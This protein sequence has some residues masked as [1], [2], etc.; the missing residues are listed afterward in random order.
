M[1]GSDSSGKK[2]L[3]R[4]LPSSSWEVE[5]LASSHDSG[6]SSGSWTLSLPGVE[7]EPFSVTNTV[8][9]DVVSTPDLLDSL[10]LEDIE[11]RLELLKVKEGSSSSEVHLLDNLLKLLELQNQMSGEEVGGGESVE[12][13]EAEVASVPSY[14]ARARSSGIESLIEQDVTLTFPGQHLQGRA[15][16]PARGK[17]TV[18][19]G[20]D[21]GNKEVQA[22][23]RLMSGQLE[24]LVRERRGLE[25]ILADQNLLLLSSGQHGRNSSS[26]KLSKLLSEVRG[27]Q[28]R[29][30]GLVRKME[31]KVGLSRTKGLRE[32]LSRWEVITQEV[33]SL[34]RKRGPDTLAS[35]MVRMG[36]IMRRIMRRVRSL[37]WSFSL[38]ATS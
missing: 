27:E 8:S 15:P 30:L 14:P 24:A 37:L 1:T 7:E 38:I 33:W 36:R 32:S 31:L 21:S 22:S 19:R 23:V 12:P 26:V 13:P 16:A 20:Q 18:S 28:Q 6:F 3:R 5:T 34:V 25:K 4:V 10:V 11:E 17:E 35:E 9:M 29:I 2:R